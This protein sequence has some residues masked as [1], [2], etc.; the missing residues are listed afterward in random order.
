M[1]LA[2]IVAG[3]A[4]SLAAATPAGADRSGREVVEATCAVCHAQGR[5]SAPRIGDA[6][7]WEKR[8]S[9]GLSSLTET[10]IAGIRRMPPHGGNFAVTDVEIKRAVVYMVNQSGGR[11]TEPIDRAHPPAPRSGEEI[12][13][14]QCT[15]CHADGRNGAIRSR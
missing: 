8:A 12:V 6:K 5:D 1:K 4:L 14:M 2:L 3:G 15:A 10:A 9:R 7:A 13:Q 11:W